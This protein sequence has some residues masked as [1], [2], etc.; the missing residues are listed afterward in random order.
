V[1]KHTVHLRCI[2]STPILTR[3]GPISFCGPR[4][5]KSVIGAFIIGSAGSEHLQRRIKSYLPRSRFMQ[6]DDEWPLSEPGTAG[7]ESQLEMLRHHL[8]EMSQH[9]WMSLRQDMK[10]PSVRRS[11]LLL[12]L[13]KAS[14][15][16]AQAKSIL[17]KVQSS[18]DEGWEAGHATRT[19]ACHGNFESNKRTNAALPRNVAVSRTNQSQTPYNWKQYY[20]PTS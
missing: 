2:C 12:M 14:D 9:R 4:F 5:A 8:S 19:F 10:L 20:A 18:E 7:G 3:L 15:G 11:E 6:M 13:E 1:R 16:D 17:H